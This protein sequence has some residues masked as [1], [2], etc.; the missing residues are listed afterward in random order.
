MDT[1]KK[2]FTPPANKPILLPDIALPV[3]LAI[4]FPQEREI[5]KLQGR[6]HPSIKKDYLR[7]AACAIYIPERLQ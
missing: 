1:A 2:S 7:D 4:L 5:G 6:Q 3:F